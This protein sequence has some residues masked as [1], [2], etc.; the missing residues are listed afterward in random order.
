[1]QLPRPL[2]VALTAAALAFVAHLALTPLAETDL[3]FHLKLGQLILENHRI[4]FQNL[5]SFTYPDSPDP[6]LASGFQ[7]LVAL[8]HRLGGFTAI[9]VLKAA[10]I[11]AAAALVARAARRAGAG[12]IAVALTVAAAGLAAEQR[13]VERPHLIT[14]VGLAALQLILVEHERGSRRALWLALPLTLVWA[15]F[16]AGVFL[17]PLTLMLYGIGHS[18]SERR[19]DWKPIG[20]ALGCAALTFC[21]PAGARLPHYLLW[22][23]G[24][25][26]T[27]IIEEFR[28]ADPYDDPW[29]FV[30]LAAALAS[31]RAA[32]LRRVLPLVVVGLLA[33]R[34]VRFVAEWAFLA[35]PAIALGVERALRGLSASRRAQSIAASAITLVL[36]SASAPPRALG[37]APDVV[38]FDAIDFVT[39]NGLR[40]R[41]YSDLD[42]GCYLLWEGW[43]RYQVFQDARLPAY[44]DE[45]HRALDETP[46]AP[47]AFDALLTRYGVETALLNDPYRNM[48]SGSFDPEEWA[49]VFRS[50]DAI[51]FARRL[52]RF[53]DVIARDE[54]PIRFHFSFT[55]GTAIEPIMQPPARSPVARCEWDRRLAAL[56]E[57]RGD[58]AHERAAFTD[59]VAHG[60]LSPVD[61]DALARYL[62]V[63]KTPAT[64]P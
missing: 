11:V 32:G 12:P 10:L 63:H 28:R 23:T 36:L 44:P 59:A 21:T 34:S 27:R 33:W 46:L 31:A 2:H 9:V 40:D 52:P 16:H 53:S 5:F 26:A 48:R 39:R 18:I 1:M 38:P 14:F 50:D 17:S 57:A 61:A 60:C 42:V 37:L 24:L 3:F 29:F 49:L 35:T 6:D 51:V 45:F 54:L 62:G 43:P 22:H 20:I 8:V 56:L 47:A 19:V 55:N 7:V 25:G 41:L 64:T 4:P 15:S 30:L 58:L 13:L